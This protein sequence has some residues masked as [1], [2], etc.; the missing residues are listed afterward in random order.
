[1]VE[2]DAL[3]VGL[4]AGASQTRVNFSLLGDDCFLGC[5]GR[6]VSSSEGGVWFSYIEVS[7]VVVGFEGAG[8]CLG[9]ERVNPKSRKTEKLFR[10][11]GVIGIQQER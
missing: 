9:V 11:R 7:E 1:M 5:L 2:L 4:E 3:M 10:V 8:N 6:L